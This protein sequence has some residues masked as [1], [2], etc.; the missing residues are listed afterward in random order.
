LHHQ[1]NV[2]AVAFSPD[3]KTVITG[4][5]DK[6][7][8]L[9]DAATGN[10]L[11]RPLQHEKQC[12]AV[13]FS[14]DGKTVLT[15]SFEAARLWETA[16]GKQIGSPL[17]HQGA[18]TTAAFSSDGKAVL[19]AAG[20]ARLWHA[21]RLIEGDPERIVLAAQVIT[22]FELDEHG[23]TRALGAAAWEQRRQRLQELGGPPGSE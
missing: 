2:F 15:G 16:T 10:P 23:G 20:T 11:G 6:T 14:P 12:L 4:S 19:T 22:G 3:G 17:W 1:A 13:A 8:R 9:W 5:A 7:A 21:P 18:V